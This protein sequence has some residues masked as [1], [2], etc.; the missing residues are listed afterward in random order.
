MLAKLLDQESGAVA[1]ITEPGGRDGKRLH[2][3]GVLTG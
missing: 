3:S 1:A 2:G